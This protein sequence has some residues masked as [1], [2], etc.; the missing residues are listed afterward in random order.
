MIRPGERYARQMIHE[1]ETRRRLLGAAVVGERRGDC[2]YYRNMARQRQVMPSRG[3]A[4]STLLPSMPSRAAAAAR[5]LMA[6]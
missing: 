2:R 5:D 4:L 1:R 6:M 3:R